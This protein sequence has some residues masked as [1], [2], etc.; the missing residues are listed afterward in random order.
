LEA[1]RAPS[2]AGEIP[3]AGIRYSPNSPQSLE[4]RGHDVAELITS[5]SINT[6]MLDNDDTWLRGVPNSLEQSQIQARSPGDC[7]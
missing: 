7:R 5:E 2:D 1:R 4:R 3:D 6:D